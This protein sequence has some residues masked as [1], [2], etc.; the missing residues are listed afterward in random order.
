MHLYT[1]TKKKNNR[2]GFTFVE[3]LVAIAVLL[4]AVTA[5]LFL[6]AQGLKVA[7]IARNQVIANYLAQEAVEYIRYRRDTNILSG[8]T[9]SNW[10]AGLSDCL[11]GSHCTIDPHVAP[12]EQIAP[13][14]GKAQTCLPLRFDPDT[15]VYGYS[16]EQ[17]SIFTRTVSLDY[18]GSDPDTEVLLSVTVSW[19]DG[20][21]ARSYTVTERMLNWE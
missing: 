8:F 7:R 6:A 19:Q 4:L 2:G 16:P 21:I 10:L 11:D 20:L 1:K 15:G 14:M 17:D 18:D 12:A 5:P 13:C 3:T 9:G